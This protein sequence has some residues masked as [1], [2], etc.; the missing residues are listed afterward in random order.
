M[1]AQ[2]E[3]AVPDER[4]ESTEVAMAGEHRPQLEAWQRADLHLRL[5]T[6]AQLWRLMAQLQI[7][8]RQAARQVTHHHRQQ[9]GRQGPPSRTRLV[10]E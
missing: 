2:G 1:E 5:R 7:V 10:A 9:M 8:A 6:T 4:E 3:A